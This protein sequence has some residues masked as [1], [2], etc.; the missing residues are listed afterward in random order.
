MKP[1][2]SVKSLTKQFGTEY[3][4]DNISLD[5]LEGEVFGLIGKSGAGKSTLA[6]C[7]NLLERPTSGDIVFEGK[8]LTTLSSAELRKARQSMGMIFQQFNLLMQC[9]VISNVTFPMEIASVARSE[10]K[11]KAR[12][13][14]AL[15]GISE[16][17]RAYPA[18]LSG[19]Q[20]QRVAIARALALTPKLIIC[21]EATSALDPETTRGILALLKDI[22]KR[23]GV[24]I[25]VITHEMQVVEEIC[26]RVA[27]LNDAKLAEIGDVRQVLSSPAT[28]EASSLVGGENAGA[29]LLR[30]IEASG[31]TVEE[32]MK[33]AGIS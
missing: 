6:R 13:L 9:S 33:R 23:L 14:L 17:E 22:N 5:I 15:V 19:G 32:V 29:R 10:A 2:L 1:I 18:Q 16:K 24:T 4:L 20:R 27:V 11:K 28:L 31:L 25:V 30:Q 12:E 21:D 8:S 26:D 3:A 7:L